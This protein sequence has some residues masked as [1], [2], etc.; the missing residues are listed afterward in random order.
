MSFTNGTCTSHTVYIKLSDAAFST[1][2]QQMDVKVKK[3]IL[4]GIA[5]NVLSSIP[6]RVVFN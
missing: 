1:R 2:W 5:E 6:V 3:K 4:I